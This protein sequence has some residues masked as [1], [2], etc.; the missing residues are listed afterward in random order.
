MT[1]EGPPIG[2]GVP[3]T[4]DRDGAFPRLGDDLLARFRSLGE[5]RA[6]Q[7]G[8]VL[9]AS[10]DQPSH[11]FIVE[12][13][14]V[15]IVQGY[16]AENRV[17]AIHGERR[18]LGELGIIIGQRLYLTCVVREPSQVI[19]LPLERLFEIVAQD[20]GLSDMILGAF[21]ARRSILIGVG[22]GMK[23]IGS[24]FSPD[25]RQLREFL[26]RN[27]MPYQWIDLEA[28]D[29]AEALLSTLAIEASETPVVV[30]SDGEILRNPDS[31]E[32]GRAIGLG[33][34]GAPPDLCDVIV[35]GAGPAGLAAGLYAASEGLD[36]QGVEAIALGGQAGTSTR[37][38]NYFGFPAGVAGIELTQRA[39]VQAAKFGARLTTPAEAV[40]LVSEPGRHEVRL[41]NGDAATGRTIV[42]ATGA[43]YRRLDVPR[44]DELEGGGVYYAAT[45]VEA[46]ECAGEPAVIVGGGNSAGQ[47]AMFLSRTSPCRLLI[48]GDDLGKSMSRYLVD[49]IERNDSIELCTNTEVVELIGERELEVVTVADARTGE[50]SQVPARG[51][52]VFIGAVPHTEWLA[53]QLATDEA[54]FLLTGRDVPSDGL[55]EF[56]GDRPLFLETSRPGIFAVGDVHS[57][58]IKRVAS[59]VGEGSMAVRMVHQRLATA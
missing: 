25:S 5:V 32:L 53:G 49:Q 11:F 52:F 3:E 21:M 29:D 18:F 47:A 45:Q 31:A 43:R 19:Q 9:F 33:A 30:A 54:G 17:I 37:I 8:E 2:A 14:S 39:A 59:A 10:G 34:P 56:N 27:R 16:G 57:G 24:R 13:G 50:R 28:D 15:A 58:S 44:L 23:L 35:V 6:V 26:A 46:Q 22:T 7:P 12:S 40:E 41:S 38:E 51:L 36:I 20:K 4:P 1:S 48:R 42:I 55:E